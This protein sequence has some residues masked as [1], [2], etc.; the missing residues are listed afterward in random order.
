MKQWMV[1]NHA[2]GS[3]DPARVEAMRAT[4]AEGGQP[5]ERVIVC[6][7][8][9]LPS[10]AEV[11]SDAV[12]RVVI[13]TGDGTIN[14]TADRLE[15]WDGEVLVLPGGT[16]NLLSRALHG[17]R[18]VDMI[19]AATLAGEVCATPV[20]VIRGCGQAAL[21]GVIA[22]PTTAWGEVREHM[23]RTDLRGLA[24]S[25]P[26]AISRTFQGEGVRVEGHPNSYQAIYLQ[27]SAN[28]MTVEGVLADHAADLVKHGWAWLTGDF[29]NGP[30]ER[31]AETDRVTL[32][33]TSP[34]GLLIDGERAE[35]ETPCSFE[36]EP[37]RLRFLSTQ[38][39][40]RW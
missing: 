33:G 14:G 8:E 29:R 32:R 3:A 28:G 21:C 38:G 31:L 7:D 36:V 37:S 10:A 9:P 12:D 17:E 19:I 5:I 16:M 30:T 11:R 34:V 35:A 25:V 24:E 4:F 15:G 6:G 18:D 20:P 27:P 39:G 40:V 1:T 13:F 22:G 26:Q 23:R 2:S